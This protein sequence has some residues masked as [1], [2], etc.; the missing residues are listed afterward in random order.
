MKLNNALAFRQ[1]SEA[2]PAER[3]IFVPRCRCPGQR[4]AKN[5]RKLDFRW[6]K[7]WRMWERDCQNATPRFSFLSTQRFQKCSPEAVEPRRPVVCG[8]ENGACSKKTTF[9]ECVYSTRIKEHTTADVAAGT[10]S[11][12]PLVFFPVNKTASRKNKQIATKTTEFSSYQ[13]RCDL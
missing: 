8:V 3:L 5:I 9:W 2:T 6:T 12:R 4:T 1:T 13:D 7:M 11:Q 10:D